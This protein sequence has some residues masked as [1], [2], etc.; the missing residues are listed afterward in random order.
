MEI[1]TD[2]YRFSIPFQKTVLDH[3]FQKIIFSSIFSKNF[4]FL[5]QLYKI[6]DLQ[7]KITF[8]KFLFNLYLPVFHNLYN[9]TVCKTDT[10]SSVSD[11]NGEPHYVIYITYLLQFNKFL[12][13]YFTKVFIRVTFRHTLDTLEKSSFYDFEPDDW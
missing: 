11:K 7:H 3:L 6:P 9:I 8:L 1:T 10:R 2:F 13:I 4:I 12:N 5:L